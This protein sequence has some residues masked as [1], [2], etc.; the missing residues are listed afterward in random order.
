MHSD[1]K[2][3]TV[4]KLGYLFIN[5]LSLRGA[6]GLS[7]GIYRSSQLFKQ[8]NWV[9]TPVG[10]SVWNFGSSLKQGRDNHIFWSE[11]G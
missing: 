9:N 7:W 6:I 5:F 3:W 11:I 4:L 2:L 1:L 10:N 8:S